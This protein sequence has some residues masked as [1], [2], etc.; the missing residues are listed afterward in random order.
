MPRAD[1]D[2]I[3]VSKPLRTGHELAEASV[4]H[5]QLGG[6]RTYPRRAV[7]TAEDLRMPVKD[8]DAGNLHIT[9]GAD[10][11]APAKSSKINL[12]HGEPP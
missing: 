12:R 8:A 6:E 1:D 7:W 9:F 3:A 10:E 4:D 2:D 11:Q 5:P